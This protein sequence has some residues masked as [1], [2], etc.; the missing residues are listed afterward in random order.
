MVNRNENSFPSPHRYPILLPGNITF[1]SNT[2]NING[3]EKSLQANQ[4]Q[5]SGGKGAETGATAM[6][7]MDDNRVWKGMLFAGGLAAKMEIRIRR[8]HIS[9]M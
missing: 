3:R 1:N 7:G 2:N 5:D 9:F 6:W 4:N 8:N